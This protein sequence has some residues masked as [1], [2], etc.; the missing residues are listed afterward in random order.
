LLER[1][2]QD[3]KQIKPAICIYI[4]I[5]ANNN[6]SGDFKKNKRFFRDSNGSLVT[7]NEDMVKE[8]EKYFE[9]LL[10]CEEPKELFTFDLEGINDQE[11]LELTLEEIELQIK[12]LKNNKS[13]G[14]DG[15]QA[16]LIKKGEEN[17]TQ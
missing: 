14:E 8:W 3:L 12:N 1:T 7:A 16:E 2:E 4:I 6:L 9:K 5:Y 10:N 15:F 13:S 17:T 11:Y